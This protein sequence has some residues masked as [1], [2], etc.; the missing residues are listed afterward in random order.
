MAD[1]SRSQRILVLGL[2]GAGCNAVG[3]MASGAPEGMPFAAVDCDARTLEQCAVENR[4]QI[5]RKVTNGLSTG[6]DLDSGRRAAETGGA[7]LETLLGNVDLLFVVCGMG[8]GLATG[9]APVI[10]RMARNFGALTLFFTIQPFP[11]EGS[12]VRTRAKAGIHRLRT[13][14]DALVRLPN[15]FIQGEG[16]E[17]LLESF[18]KSDRQIAVGVISI[19]QMLAKPGVCNLD[20][21]SIHTMLHY[22]D[23]FCHFAFAEAEGEGRAEELVRRLQAHPLTDGGRVLREAAG[24]LVGITGGGDL[25][26]EEVETVMSALVPEDDENRWSKLGVTVDPSAT[27]RLAAMVLSAEAWKKP[28]VDDGRDGLKPVENGEGELPGLFKPGSRAFGGAERTIYKGEDLDIP[29]YIRRK[30]KLPR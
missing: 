23:G 16:D 30:I 14:A 10:A 29:A 24:M 21:S 18:A 11:F 12:P 26:L 19:W 6:G 3:H 20:F 4:L 13:Y 17:P 1:L 15:K 22:C 25:R 7:Q 5:G 2:G 28:L 8:G 9:A 27:G